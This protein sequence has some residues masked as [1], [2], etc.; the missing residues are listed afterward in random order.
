[1]PGENPGIDLDYMAR[2]IHRG[3]HNMVQTV[4][5]ECGAMYRAGGDVPMRCVGE[6]EFVQGQ[7]AMS[8]SGA[9]GPCELA[10]GMFG[11]VNLRLGHDADAVLAAHVDASPSFRGIRGAF[12]DDLNEQWSS[13]FAALGKR[14]L[15]WEHCVGPAHERLKTIAQLAA[16]HPTVTIIIDHLGGRCDPDMSG[17]AFEEWKQCL[18]AVAACPNVYLKLGGAQQRMGD[19][20]PPFHMY[21]RRTPIGSEELCDT[22]FKWYSHAI[23]VFGPSRCMFE[24]NFPVDKECC[25]YRTLW[26]MFKRVAARK[27][28]SDSEKADLFAGTARRAYRLPRPAA[29]SKL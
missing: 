3:G 29:P 7:R 12:P 28:L 13:G 22:L 11:S 16:A 10:A 9:F 19:W 18:A 8:N 27:G 4:F 21:N 2:E 20:L 25:S 17:A 23:D 26:N 24:S 6:T 14:Q 15:S 1:M 5:A